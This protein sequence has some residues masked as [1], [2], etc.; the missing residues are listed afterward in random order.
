MSDLAATNCGSCGCDD[1][2]CN[3]IFLILIL[4]V[5][6]CGNSGTDLLGGDNSCS[7]IIWI[8][9]ILCACGGNGNNLFG[10]GC[11]C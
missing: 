3:I 7:C 2:G 9:L 11:G 6:G 1:G 10:N 5:C 4:L 8:L